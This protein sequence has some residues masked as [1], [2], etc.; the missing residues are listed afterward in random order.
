MKDRPKTGHI[1][2]LTGQSGEASIANGN[3]WAE[4]I[5]SEDKDEGRNPPLEMSDIC[6]EELAK[7]RAMVRELDIEKRLDV[8]LDYLRDFGN[9]M[10]Q[11]NGG[12]NGRYKSECG[13]LMK[14]R[15]HLDMPHSGHS[16]IATVLRRKTSQ[17]GWRDYVW[18]PAM[19]IGMIWREIEQKWSFHS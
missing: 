14:T 16:F 19:T 12:P 10:L 17:A 3:T 8:A 6:R 18:Q 5:V 1:Y 7:T 2:K 13:R 4:S 9:P 11:P 15:L